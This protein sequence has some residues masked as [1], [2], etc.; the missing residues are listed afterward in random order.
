MA[1][2]QCTTTSSRSRPDIDERRILAM[3]AIIVFVVLLVALGAAAFFDRTPDSRD[4]AYGVG[5]IID[6]PVRPA[7]R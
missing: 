3:A 1:G 4:I 7:A 5:P 2:N 6:P